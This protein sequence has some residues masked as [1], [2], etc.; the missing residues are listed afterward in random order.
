MQFWGSAHRLCTR[1]RA[2]QLRR[3][4]SL[5]HSALGRAIATAPIAFAQGL[6]CAIAMAPVVF[7]QGMGCA[8]ATARI[9][10]S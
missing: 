7:A 5:L 4:P 10:S 3:R 2:G 6:G 1:A 8:I 9:A